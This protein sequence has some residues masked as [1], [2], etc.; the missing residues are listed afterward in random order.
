MEKCV[1]SPKFLVY[2]WK[3]VSGVA[4][5]LI[6]SEKIDSPRKQY[7]SFPPYLNPSLA[8]V[9]IFS[10]QVLRRLGSG[11]EAD[12]DPLGAVLVDLDTGGS[13]HR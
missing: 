1:F 12:V 8:Q 7:T 9:M 3:K 4:F 13:D 10:S 11:E 6:L 2:R 5:R